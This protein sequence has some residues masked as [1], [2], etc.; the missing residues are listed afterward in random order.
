M[1]LKLKIKP[2]G[3]SYGVTCSK[4]ID[5][6]GDEIELELKDKPKKTKNF[7]NNKLIS[8]AVC[9]CNG[10]MH[11][12]GVY[13]ICDNCNKIIGMD[14]KV[15]SSQLEITKAKK[16]KYDYELKMKG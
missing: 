14:R 9:S 11:K 5:Y 2:C 1:I 8:Y 7:K 15:I 10:M 16:C 4:L 6:L 3:K 12:Y 13:F